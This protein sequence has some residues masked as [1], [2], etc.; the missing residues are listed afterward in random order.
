MAQQVGGDS[1]DVVRG[2]RGRDGHDLGGGVVTPRAGEVKGVVEVGDAVVHQGAVHG[3]PLGGIEGA[4]HEGDLGVTEVLGGDEEV[5][6]E[7]AHKGG[8]QSDELCERDGE[9]G[10]KVGGGEVGVLVPLCGEHEGDGEQAVDVCGGDKHVRGGLCEAVNV[11]AGG[12]EGAARHVGGVA[13]DVVEEG[14]QG[15]GGVDLVK[16]GAGGTQGGGVQAVQVGRGERVE[17]RGRGGIDQGGHVEVGGRGGGQV[18][19]VVAGF[20]SGV[21]SG[22]YDVDEDW[23]AVDEGEARG[24]G[25][26]GWGRAVVEGVVSDG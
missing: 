23:G 15:G 26:G 3:E 7:G 17:Q 25:A 1:P 6:V 9:K 12:D 4:R 13:C 8:L 22:V 14:V 24:G 19:P 20:R 2:E 10:G 16:G 18:E 5:V 11:D 21:E